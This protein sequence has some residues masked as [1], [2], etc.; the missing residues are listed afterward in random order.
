[1]EKHIEEI[2]GTGS[3]NTGN[4]TIL[5]QHHSRMTL[6]LEEEMTIGEIFAKNGIEIESYEKIYLDRKPVDENTIIE[7]Y[8]SN[9]M[10]SIIFNGKCA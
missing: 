2:S 4:L 8:G 9:H 7:D 5:R 3:H 10:V 6:E 1:M